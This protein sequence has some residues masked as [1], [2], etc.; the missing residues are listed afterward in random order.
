MTQ[1]TAVQGYQDGIYPERARQ[2]LRKNED[3]DCFARREPG[4]L[5]GDDDQG[6]GPAERGDL[7][8]ALPGQRGHRAPFEHAAQEGA[9]AAGDRTGSVSVTRSDRSARSPAPCR[10]ASAGLTNSWNDT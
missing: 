2:A 5:L 9:P 10:A 4:F 6:V 3:V 1:A 8:R 7:V